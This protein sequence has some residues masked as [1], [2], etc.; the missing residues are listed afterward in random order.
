MMFMNERFRIMRENLW[1][2]TSPTG[3]RRFTAMRNWK[4]ELLLTNIGMQP[5]MNY[6]LLARYEL[7]G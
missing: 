4:R 3:G 2:C 6:L 1:R 5:N 7:M